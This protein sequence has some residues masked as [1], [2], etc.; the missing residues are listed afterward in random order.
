MKAVLKV[1]FKF[2]AQGTVLRKDNEG[3]YFVS[4]PD[5]DYLSSPI[6]NQ[7]ITVNGY[8][9]ESH[10]ETFELIDKDESKA[11]LLQEAIQL[12]NGLAPHNDVAQDAIAKI[13][14]ALRTTVE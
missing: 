5:E 12:L 7:K 2:L 13:N 14:L 3:N 9:V 10:P 11:V 6:N 8:F 4:I 1:N